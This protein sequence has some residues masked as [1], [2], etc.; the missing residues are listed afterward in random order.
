V[1]FDALF[2][3]AIGTAA[4]ACIASVAARSLREFSRRELEEICERRQRLE[5]FEDILHH[6]ERMAISAE[7]LAAFLVTC[8]VAS[9]TIWGWHNFALPQQQVSWWLLAGITVAISLIVI[10]IVV[11]LPWSS[12]LDRM[13]SGWPPFLSA[14][15]LCTDRGHGAA[16]DYRP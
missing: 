8:S 13:E 15:R 11:A 16:S 4:A 12:H 3:I 10:A 6:H 5:R 14:G 2:W 9:A 1:N 7:M